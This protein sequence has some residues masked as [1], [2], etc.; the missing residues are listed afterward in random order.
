MIDKDFSNV[1]F[2]KSELRSLKKLKHKTRCYT[3][4]YEELKAKGYVD[5]TSYYVD[6]NRMLQHRTDEIK[7]TEIGA[8]FLSYRRKKFIKDF[9]FDIVNLAIALAALITAVISILLQQ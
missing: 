7:L 4:T 3:D 5:F 8:A 1:T 9:L 2:T 6:E